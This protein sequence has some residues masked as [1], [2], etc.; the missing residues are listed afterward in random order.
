M[1]LDLDVGKAAALLAPLHR[2]PGRQR[3]R[4]A[5][6][7]RPSPTE[8]RGCSSDTEPCCRST[9]LDAL[10]R[11]PRR[12]LESRARRASSRADAYVKL[13]REFAELGPVVDAVQALSRGGRRARRPRGDDRGSGDRRRD[14]RHGGR[15]EDR[16]SRRGARRSSRRSARAAAQ[17][18]DG[19][20]QRHPR[21]PRRHRRR[22]GR[23]VRRRPL[24]HV[25][26]LRR[27]AG[28]EGRGDVGER[29]HDGRL[30]GDHRRDQRARRR[31][32]G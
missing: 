1:L 4:S 8:P 19:R 2:Q 25:R 30:Q 31:S 20:A 5:S 18:R 21:D 17:G 12:R 28:L 3:R 27:Q 6:G 32:P 13:S 24:P 10:L 15:G 22:R 9:K 26:A 23:A 11:A 7:S 29:R 14:A 16:S